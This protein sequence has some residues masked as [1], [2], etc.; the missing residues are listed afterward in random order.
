MT[1][2]N[3][4]TRR[5][6]L[7]TGAAVLGTVARASESMPDAKPSSKLTVAIFSKHLLFLQGSRLAEGAAEIGFDGVDL[8]VRKGSHVEPA[9]VRQDLPPMIASLRSHGLEVPMITTDIVD[10]DSPYAGDVLATMSELGIRYYRWGGLQYSP[11]GSLAKQLDS[12]K[13]RVSKV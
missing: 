5:S 7:R 9:R 4:I 11:M 6:A 13:P 2:A 8:A 3:A 1:R 10:A 12:F